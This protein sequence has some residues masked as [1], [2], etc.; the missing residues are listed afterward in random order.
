MSMVR[1]C[2]AKRVMPSTV[3]CNVVIVAMIVV[4]HGMVLLRSD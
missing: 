1:G 4:V 3:S 2:V